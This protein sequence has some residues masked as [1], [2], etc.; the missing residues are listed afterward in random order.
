MRNILLALSAVLLMLCTASC[1][2]KNKLKG[3]YTFENNT[4]ETINLR[5]YKTLDDYANSTNPTLAVRMAPGDTYKWNY[6]DGDEM[7][8]QDK[9][10]YMDWYTDDYRMSNWGRFYDPNPSHLVEDP[11]YVFTR[12][13]YGSNICVLLP[14]DTTYWRQTV[15][16]GNENEVLWKAIDARDRKR[17]TSIWKTLTNDERDCELLIRKTH[18]SSL[19]IANTKSENTDITF[20]HTAQTGYQFLAIGPVKDNSQQVYP[21]YLHRKSRNSTIAD[22]TI[23]LQTQRCEYIFT[24]TK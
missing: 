8:Q 9:T 5:M 3:P 21:G 14:Y 13:R 18:I 20:F 10:F 15:I 16:R 19:R 22:D 23:L 6:T 17:D 11:P 2:K 1:G 12:K 4:G 24:R 7:L